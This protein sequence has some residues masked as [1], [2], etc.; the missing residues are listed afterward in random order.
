ME[1][2]NNSKTFEMEDYNITI[3]QNKQT[4]SSIYLEITKS[5]KLLAKIELLENRE[6]DSFFDIQIQSQIPNLQNEYS[7]Y[8]NRIKRMLKNI[9]LINK[10]QK[11]KILITLEIIQNKCIF[12]I[13]HYLVNLLMISLLVSGIEMKFVAFSAS[14]FLDEN[15]NII[16]EK[17]FKEDDE[18]SQVFLCKK[19]GSNDDLV[20][21]KINGNI[22]KDKDLSK[23]FSFLFAACDKVGREILIYLKNIGL[24][25]N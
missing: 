9:V 25:S 11:T 10:I 18:I 3:I 5:V 4:L 13:Y 23:V 8:Q 1:I 14:C 22:G 21:F 6:M 12:D 19:M 17:D 15:F 7:I 16:E 24:A 2:E 20:S